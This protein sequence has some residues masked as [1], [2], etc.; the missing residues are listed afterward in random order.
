[1]YAN[2]SQNLE[3]V[4][5]VFQLIILAAVL[6]GAGYLLRNILHSVVESR[7]QRKAAF[8]ESLAKTRARAAA[9]VAAR[10]H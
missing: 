1:M 4:G 5:L 7:R 9:R 2:I 3:F 6:C 10:Q 8:A